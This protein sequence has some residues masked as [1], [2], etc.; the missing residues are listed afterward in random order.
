MFLKIIPI[1]KKVF[2]FSIMLLVACASSH[3]QKEF[4]AKI[5][6]ATVYLQGLAERDVSRFDDGEVADCEA[7]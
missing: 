5:D 6:H 4:T 3:A 7:C 2:V 1:M